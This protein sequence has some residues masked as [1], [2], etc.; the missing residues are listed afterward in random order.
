MAYCVKGIITVKVGCFAHLAS[1]AYKRLMLPCSAARK[2]PQVGP[3][4]ARS[5]EIV[6][7]PTGNPTSGPRG[8]GLGIHKGQVASSGDHFAGCLSSR[9]AEPRA[10]TARG[11]GCRTSRR[12]AC[13]T[14][15]NITITLFGCQGIPELLAREG[16]LESRAEPFRAGCLNSGMG[17]TG[18]PQICPSEQAINFRCFL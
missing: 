3:C 18:P 9:V 16:E 2:A 1:I 10:E 15:C 8:F 13:Y 17:I 11:F 5:V 7:G 14:V 4:W 12:I 6:F